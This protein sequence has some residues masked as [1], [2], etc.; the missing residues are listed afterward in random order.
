MST[1]PRSPS[2]FEQWFATLGMVAIL[3]WVGSAVY[4]SHLFWLKV[5]ALVFVGMFVLMGGFIAWM[6]SAQ[7][8]DKRRC[9]RE[10]REW[11]P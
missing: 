5:V 4:H 6:M 3:A 2:R 7:W 1:P 8:L 11:R 10:G 9:A